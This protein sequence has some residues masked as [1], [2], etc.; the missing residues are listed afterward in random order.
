MTT[1]DMNMNFIPII[2]SYNPINNLDL[3]ARLAYCSCR[4][5]NSEKRTYLNLTNNSFDYF[6]VDLQYQ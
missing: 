2:F 4:L 1:S 3:P 6:S 5:K